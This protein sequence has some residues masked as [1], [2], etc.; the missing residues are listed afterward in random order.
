MFGIVLGL[1]ICRPFA[2][3][4]AHA[5]LEWTIKKQLNLGTTPLDIS[6]SA[7]GKMIFILVPG[8]ILVYSP[9]KDEVMNQIPAEE[10]FDRM[11][12]SAKD[13]A[14]ILSNSSEQTLMII[15]L[16]T[17]HEISISGLP[18]KGPE[19][20]PVTIAAFN[21]YQW[22]YCARLVPLLQQ[23]L[24]KY[25]DDVK[26]VFKN[27]PL[28]M[29]KSAKKG[30]IAALAANAQGKFW[31]FHDK[32]FENHRALNDE[33]IQEI[34]E[35]LGLNMEKF[36]TDMKDPDIQQLITKDM[37]NGQ[38]AGVRGTPTV[39]VN[40]KR[41]K[42][43]SLQNFQEMIDAELKKRKENSSRNPGKP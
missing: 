9:L 22:P 19:N 27:F 29:H 38:Q 30:A 13:N 31:E 28:A 20:A 11:T 36:N 25:P 34:A 41:L 32:L 23:V 3:Q 33:K 4:L 2:P 15:Q 40:G 8:E 5:D 7:D 6:T 42:K 1:I 17:V 14:L 18:I 12:F 21:D 16:Q 37:R 26:L 43:R 24:E 39:F 35:E 10:G